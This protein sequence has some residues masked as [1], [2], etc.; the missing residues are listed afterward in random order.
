MR[1]A[2]FVI[3]FT[4][5]TLV[6]ASGFGLLQAGESTT[7]HAALNSIS[8]EEAGRYLEVL[9]DDTFE[10]RE[11]GTRGGRAAGGYLV[12]FLRENGIQ[13]GGEDGGYYQAFLKGYRNV[14]GFI[15]GR[16]P[17]LK[18]EYIVLGAHYDHV[19]YGQPQNSY[20]PTGQIHNGA[21]DNASGTAGLME[22]VQAFTLLPQPPRR[23]VLFAFWDG[24]EI[25]L[26]GSKHWVAHPTVPLESVRL[27]FNLDMIGRL[28]DNRLE[29][30]GARSAHG[31]RTLISQHNSSFGLEL[32]FIWQAE[33]NSDHYP[34]FERGIPFLML[35]TGMHDQYHRPTDKAH[36][37]NREGIRAVAQL[38][39]CLAHEL[40]EGDSIPAYRAASRHE[41]DYHRRQ[42]ER[43]LPPT[44]PRL[45]VA[46]RNE[47]TEAGLTVTRV[48]PDSAAERAGVRVGDR[49]I[50]FDGQVVLDSEHCRMLI[51]ASS[52]PATARVARPGLEEAVELTIELPGKPVRLG[53]S[54]DED[55]AEPATVMLTRI[56]PGSA[57]ERAGLAPHDRVHAVDG[58][59][60][61]GSAGF[62]ALVTTRS[63]PIELL[64]ERR[65]RLRTITLEPLDQLM[66]E[67]PAAVGVGAGS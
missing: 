47:V 57:A 51:L 4:G 27:K 67:E 56:V 38:T 18:H 28:R 26:L 24:E 23:S 21:D 5:W 65:G 2:R 16:D 64:V 45:G 35:H 15:P 7:F 25:G 58:E 50:E 37:I 43:T 12:Q 60:F 10:G 36:L 34:F 13:P 48:V 62:Q 40:A 53:V 55:P 9:A 33:A 44:P 49:L 42:F 61:A 52:S 39:F 63:G 59:S 20:G 3:R 19:G 30:Y 22:V 6:V 32:D 54:W 66:A 14:L 17:E 8:A 46:W 31:L 11:A 1:L 41:S 29:I